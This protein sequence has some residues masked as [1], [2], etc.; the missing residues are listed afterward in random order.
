MPLV[1]IIPKVTFETGFRSAHMR[2]AASVGVIVRVGGGRRRGL[3]IWDAGFGTALVSLRACKYAKPT[4]TLAEKQTAKIAGLRY[5]VPAFAS[6]NIRAS[7]STVGPGCGSGFSK[8]TWSGGTSWWIWESG[9][10][11]WCL[12]KGTLLWLPSGDVNLYRTC[13]CPWSRL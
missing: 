5:R 3:W 4:K 2:A 9:V 7:N 10:F 1:P 11:G 13:R 12:D 6:S 8:G